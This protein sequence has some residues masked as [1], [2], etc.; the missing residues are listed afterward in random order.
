MNKITKRLHWDGYHSICL[1]KCTV[2]IWEHIDCVYSNVTL[3]GL[4][5]EVVYV[6]GFPCGRDIF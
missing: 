5:H 2:T 4:L 6:L 3:L 1:V